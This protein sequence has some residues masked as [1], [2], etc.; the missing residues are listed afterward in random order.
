MQ[1][2]PAPEV[3]PERVAFGYDLV[4]A[5]VSDTLVPLCVALLE[6]FLL[7]P[8]PERPSTPAIT[9]NTISFF[10]INHPFCWESNPVLSNPR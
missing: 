4:V 1:A 6:S 10:T 8:R 5:F 7:Q 9:A 2:R 3:W